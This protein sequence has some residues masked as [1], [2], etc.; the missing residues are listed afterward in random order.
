PFVII[1]TAHSDQDQHVGYDAGADDFLTKPIHEMDL[2]MRLRSCERIIHLQRHELKLQQKYYAS[3]KQLKIQNVNLEHTM[4]SLRTTEEKLQNSLL[5]ASEAKRTKSA[6][7]A[8]MSH[9]L[10]TPLNAVIGYADILME[11]MEEGGSAEWLNSMGKV[12]RSSHHLLLMINDLLDISKIEARTMRLNVEEFELI[13]LVHDVVH[14]IEPII[15][16]NDNHFEFEVGNV[17]AHMV[18]DPVRVKQV[19]YNL[20]SNAAKFTKKGTI[21]LVI[22]EKKFQEGKCLTFEVSDTGIGLSQ[23][24]MANIF[25]AFA[26]VDPSSTREYGGVGLGLA[27][28]QHLCEMLGG[29]IDVA[30]EKGKGATFTVK[31]PVEHAAPTDDSIDGVDG[32]DDWMHI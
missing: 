26:Q 11:E 7:L 14:T 25:T 20:L 1:I 29:S 13:E 19:L 22:T 15:K 18:S 21:R 4:Q 16:E 3:N 8:N 27:I 9:E 12:S 28:T 31:L 10:R 24:Q 6:F 23:S 5:V 2:L 17:I 32:D 30:S